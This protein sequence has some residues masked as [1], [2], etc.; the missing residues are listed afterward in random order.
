LPAATTVATAAV[1]TAAA[2][3]VATAAIT[4][5][6]CCP[7]QFFVLCQQIFKVQRANSRVLL[8]ARAQLLIYSFSK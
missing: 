8:G 7:N 2:T 1:A 3:V 4:A 5:V 6:V